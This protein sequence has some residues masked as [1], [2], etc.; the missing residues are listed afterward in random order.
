LKS[1]LPSASEEHLNLSSAFLEYKQR[2]PTPG[3][4]GLLL[5]VATHFR[6]PSSFEMFVYV[7]QLLQA[8]SIKTACE[9]FRRQ[10]PYCMGSLYWQLNDI[11]QG[12]SW[13]S[14]EY[15]GTWKILHYMACHF[16][17]P[18]LVSVVENQ[19]K[20][21]VWVTNDNNCDV[22]EGLLTV[23]VW[24][25]SGKLPVGTFTQ[26]ITSV[27]GSSACKWSLETNE[28]LNRVAKKAHEKFRDLAF[29]TCSVTGTCGDQKHTVS[30]TFYFSP[31]KN[32]QLPAPTIT[33]TVS[34]SSSTTIS[35]TLKSDVVAPYVHLTSGGVLGKFSEN[36]FLLLPDEEKKSGVHNLG[37]RNQRV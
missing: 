24:E 21:E 37:R 3:N 18:L 30:N 22:T 8:I 5:H 20:T 16:Y 17:A 35:L 27:G 25:Y 1:V 9:H 6:V 10:M 19:E 33:K 7:S 31:L 14:L 28:I 29:I 34:K 2:S 36:G 11:W 32:V 13:S 23:S 26:E 4:K 12:P 15:D